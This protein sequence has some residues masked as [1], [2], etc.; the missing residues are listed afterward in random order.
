MSGD[1]FAQVVTNLNSSP[2]RFSLQFDETTIVSNLSQIFFFI[3]T[4]CERRLDKDCRHLATTTK[5]TVVKKLVY[6]FFRASIFRDMFSSV[7]TDGAPVMLGRNS[8][9]GES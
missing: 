1:I 7:C 8:D 6:D 2:A 4:L 3:P 9:F 5:A